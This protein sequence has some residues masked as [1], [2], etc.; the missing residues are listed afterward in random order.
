MKAVD[1]NVELVRPEQEKADMISVGIGVLA[2]LGAYLLSKKLF[3]MSAAAGPPP[4]IS[5]SSGSVHFKH[6]DE[7]NG[8]GEAFHTLWNAGNYSHWTVYYRPDASS[9]QQTL[10]L[11]FNVDGEL[12]TNSAH[13]I[14]LTTQKN[15]SPVNPQV[16]MKV[17]TNFR[18]KPGS[19]SGDYVSESDEMVSSFSFDGGSPVLAGSYPTFDFYAS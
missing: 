12:A 15:N 18:F 8:G 11:P 17:R 1:R 4:D 2:G 14:T 3:A 5:I 16:R 19:G 7:D 10:T 13:T 6:V 9:P